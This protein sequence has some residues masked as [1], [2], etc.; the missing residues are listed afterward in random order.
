MRTGGDDGR[1]VSGRDVDGGDDGLDVGGL[2]DGVDG[3][4]LG[5]D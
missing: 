3:R 5:G 4:E 2:Y 1:E